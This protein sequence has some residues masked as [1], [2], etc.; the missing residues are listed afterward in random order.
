MIIQKILKWGLESVGLFYS[1]YEGIVL[2]IEDPTNTGRVLI[3]VPSIHFSQ[4]DSGI[5]AYPKT[6]YR[7]KNAIVYLPVAVGDTVRV[8][9]TYGKLKRA[10]FTWGSNP[11]KNGVPDGY[12]N[13]DLIAI[14]TKS[15]HE[16]ILDNSDGSFT[17]KTSKTSIS[18]DK[19]G[20]IN[21]GNSNQAFILNGDKTKEVL[22]VHS[23]TD[24]NII[25]ALVAFATSAGPSSTNPAAFAT[26]VTA[27]QGYLPGVQTNKTKIDNLSSKVVKAE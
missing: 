27:L 9:F 17:L 16:I 24:I 15:G 2:S 12:K 19:D 10:L 18:V 14:K 7:G 1:T 20:V 5:W 6:T 3:N 25:N 4:K 26:L 8:E 13:K 21:L 11:Q 22:G 23:S